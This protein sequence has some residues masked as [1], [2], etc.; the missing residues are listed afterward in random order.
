MSLPACNNQGIVEGDVFEKIPRPESMA[1]VLITKAGYG[2]TVPW[3]YRIYIQ[4]SGSNR[5]FEV[6]RADKVQDLNAVWEPDDV[7]AIKMK[8]GRIFSFQNFFDVLS[9][10]GK[11][12]KRLIIKLETSGPCPD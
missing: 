10:E 5:V 4:P 8:C 11:L 1:T 12:V 3:V 6:L 9:A 2:V 7:L